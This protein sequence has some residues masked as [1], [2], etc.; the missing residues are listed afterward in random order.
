MLVT[1]CVYAEVARD[2]DGDGPMVPG[3]L[4]LS[5]LCVAAAHRRGSVGQALLAGLLKRFPHVS[6]W[7]PGEDS[8]AVLRALCFA[9]AGRTAVV[10]GMAAEQLVR[11]P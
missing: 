7:A 3:P 11:E 10:R 6:A 4:H 9:P 1:G 8:A 2:Q 5:L